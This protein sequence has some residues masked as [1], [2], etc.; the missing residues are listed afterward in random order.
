MKVR[1]WVCVLSVLT[2]LVTG[3]GPSFHHF[4]DLGQPG[5]AR[6]NACDVPAAIKLQP[7]SCAAMGIVKFS[8]GTMP[9]SSMLATNPPS[10]GLVGLSTSESC[11]GKAGITVTQLT[12]TVNPGAEIT[13][14]YD[15]V[16]AYRV[17]VVGKVLLPTVAQAAV[18]SG[19]GTI[20]IGTP[21]QPRLVSMTTPV[22]AVSMPAEVPMNSDLWKPS[23]L[24]GVMPLS[25]EGLQVRFQSLIQCGAGQ[26][27]MVPFLWEIDSLTLTP[28]LP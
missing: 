13:S 9:P 22:S 5:D 3:C 28:V 8:G 2:I 16:P 19:S 15:N 11:S 10:G 18:V 20:D 17:D 6:F 21:L 1:K 23:V 27:L 26:T 7:S 12:C 14:A 24:S 25:K 4:D